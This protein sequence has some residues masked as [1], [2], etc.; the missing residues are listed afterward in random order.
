M[1]LLNFFTWWYGAGLV[2]HVGHIVSV[3]DLGLGGFRRHHWPYIA[4][5]TLLDLTGTTLAFVALRVMD[6]SVASFLNQ[7]QIVFS[8]IIGRLFLNEV[9]EGGEI[10]AAGVIVAGVVIMTM[11]SGS[12]PFLAVGFMIYANI[13]SAAN[14]AIVRK[15]G[16]GVGIYTFARIR[17]LTL[18]TVFFTVN[19]ITAPLALPPLIPLTVIIAGAFFGPFL[20]VIAI[21]KALEDITAGKLALYRSIQP[22]FV[23]MA[24]AAFLHTFPGIRETVGGIIV[25]IGCILLAWRHMGH[26][27]GLRTPIRGIRW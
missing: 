20:N 2:Y 17:T 21:Y 14:M 25:I 8:I 4:A 11:R 16:C 15:V 13:T 24:A 18:F 1:S 9:L 6:P 22:F 12:A 3:Q 19:V 10:A 7:S 5:Y 26:V 23:M 27:I